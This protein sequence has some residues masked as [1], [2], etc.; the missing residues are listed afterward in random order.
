MNLTCCWPARA[1]AAWEAG[2]N[3]SRATIDWCFRV[4]DARVKLAKLYPVG[5]EQSSKTSVSDH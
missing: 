3:A 2:R 4:A 5:P 1:V